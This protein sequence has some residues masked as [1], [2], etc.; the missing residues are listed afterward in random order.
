MAMGR[1]FMGAAKSSIHAGIYVVIFAEKEASTCRITTNLVQELNTFASRADVSFEPQ[2]CRWDNTSKAR[3]SPDA[4]YGA[5]G[6]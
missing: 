2:V 3:C 5:V 6:R 4:R 1:G